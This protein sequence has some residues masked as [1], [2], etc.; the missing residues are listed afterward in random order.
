MPEVSGT[1]YTREDCELCEEAVETLRAVAA[2]EDVDLTLDLVD[3]DD[4][5][6]LRE[7]YG[8]RVPYV[9]LED[10]P[11]FKYRVDPASARSVLRALA[12]AERTD[13]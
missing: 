3:V 10:R 8:E 9:L 5:H 1:V 7:E 12:G 2:D 6:D 4:D 11:A 13:D